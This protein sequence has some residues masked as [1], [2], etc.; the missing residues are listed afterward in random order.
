MVIFHY[1]VL[2]LLVGVK[3]EQHFLFKVVL[4]LAKF[5]RCECKRDKTSSIGI[6]MIM[7][8]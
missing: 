1:Y 5:G 7:K 2:S 4:K 3:T 6:C 8:Y